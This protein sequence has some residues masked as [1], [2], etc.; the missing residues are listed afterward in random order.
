M[1]GRIAALLTM[2]GTALL[3]AGPQRAAAH[4]TTRSFVTLSREGAAVEARIR[5]AFRDIEVVAWMDEDLD[6]RITW[7]EALRQLDAVEAYVGAGFALAAGGPCALDRTGAEPSTAGGVAYL[8]LTFAGSCPSAEAPLAVHTELFAD[9]DP[10]HRVFLQASVGG[11]TRTA[12]LSASEPAIMLDGDTE[13]PFAAF[14]TYFRSGVEHLLGGADHLVFLL[15]LMMPA[16]AQAARPRAAALGVLTAVTG[17]TLAHALTLTAATTALLRPPSDVINVLI[18]LSI[19]ITAVDN[20]RPFIP[21]PRAGVAAFFG[22]IHGF[23]FATALDAAQFS[24]GG[25]AVALVGFNLG[26]EAAQIGLVLVTMPALYML[27][28]GRRLTW[29]VSAGAIVVGLAWLWQRL[30]PFVTGG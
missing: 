15:V 18:A 17:F 7:G 14:R 16:V 5:V 23:G 9:I 13:G 24:G 28:G 20:V 25:L 6:R 8:D 19:V 12:L 10:D 27:G 2:L 26:I 30:A 29:V 1:T 11:G 3:L 22:L 4:E 21:A